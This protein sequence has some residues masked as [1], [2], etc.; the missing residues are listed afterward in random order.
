MWLLKRLTEAL[1]I[2]LPICI[3]YTLPQTVSK[4]P[5]ERWEELQC[6]GCRTHLGI[7]R[8]CKQKSSCDFPWILG[9][10]KPV[11]NQYD[12]NN[13]GLTGLQH[14]SS[15]PVNLIVEDIKFYRLALLQNVI[16]LLLIMN[17]KPKNES[18]RIL[19]SIVRL[20]HIFFS[21]T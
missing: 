15:A 21:V 11:Q 2:K 4:W 16:V 7:A 1:I 3:L 9:F 6:T 18:S 17:E 10:W 14:V 13:Q 12:G 20:C 5:A 19:L 8:S